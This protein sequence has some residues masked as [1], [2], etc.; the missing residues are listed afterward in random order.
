MRHNMWYTVWNGDL[1][2]ATASLTSG[3]MDLRLC[4]AKEILAKVISASGAAD[5]KIE[6]AVSPDGENFGAFTD[7]D[8]VVASTLGEFL[9]PEGWCRVAFPQINSPYLKLKI[10]GGAT[11]SADTLVYLKLACEEV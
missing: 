3:V 5:A 9:T 4:Q 2:N 10:T 1:L 8:P 6:Y 7:A 11:N